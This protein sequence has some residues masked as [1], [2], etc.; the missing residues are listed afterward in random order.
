M[1]IYLGAYLYF[2]FHVAKNNILQYGMQSYGKS[3]N[4][5][6]FTQNDL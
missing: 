3:F 4:H 2:P 5:E 1:H 6:H